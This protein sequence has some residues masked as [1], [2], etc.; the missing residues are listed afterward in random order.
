MSS[1]ELTL[2]S[3]ILGTI[4]YPVSKVFRFT[5]PPLGLPDMQRFLLLKDGDLYWLQ[6]IDLP[7][8]VLVAVDPIQLFGYDLEIGYED[9]REIQA[10]T[11]EAILV[12]S[13]VQLHPDPNKNTC[14]L[15]APIILSQESHLAMQLLLRRTDVPRYMPL[16]AHIGVGA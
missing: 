7:R 11:E 16:G 4:R 9:Q 14:N 8:L 6:N 5:E 1:H 15:H 12:L 10:T 13:L 2:E 3:P